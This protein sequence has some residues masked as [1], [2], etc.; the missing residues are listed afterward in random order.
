[1]KNKANTETLKIL[2]LDIET[3]PNIGYTWGKYE[4]DVIEFISESHLLS[5]SVKWLDSKKTE[6]FALP[7]FKSYK[8]N[9]KCDKQLCEKLK[10][11]VDQADIIVGHNLDRFDMKKINT[12]LAAN[13]I[14]PPAPYKTVDTL[15]VL[16]KHFGL[17]SNKLND[18]GSYFGLGEKIDTGGFSLWKKCM[19]GDPNAWKLMKLYNKNDVILLEKVYLKVRP[20]I[21][22]H[23]SVN[24][25]KGCK[26]SSCGSGNV[27]MRGYN[28]SK[29]GKA[30]RWMCTECF[31]W[32]SGGYEKKLED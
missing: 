15:K 26:C 6:V 7:D 18:V 9:K 1:M 32:S 21:S 17:N 14:T 23:P 30:Q 13:S 8:E 27:Q 22:N 5:F 16:K 28:Y 10:E 29:M 19:S 3:S 2:F 24:I 20:W 25:N 11:Y 31:S 4:Q 12:R